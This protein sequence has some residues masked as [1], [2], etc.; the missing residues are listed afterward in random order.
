MKSSGYLGL[1]AIALSLLL[2]AGCSNS[3]SPS[4]TGELKILLTDSPAQY[5]EVN[6][7]VTQ[8]EVHA[9][10]SDSLSGWSVVNNDTATYDLLTLRNGA[11]AILG[12]T[13]LPVGKYTQ[14]R[15]HIGT[16]SNIVVG[17][18]RFPLDVTSDSIVKLNNEFDILSGALYLLTLD[19][20]A[21]KSIVLTGSGHYK[22]NPV[23]RVEANVV[24]GSISGIVNPVSARAMVSTLAG[25]DT[26]ETACDTVS[27][28]FELV[29]LPEGMYDVKISPSDVTYRDTTLTGIQVTAQHNTNVGI[30]VLTH[31]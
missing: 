18:V 5:D 11:N 15:L 3:T 17:G 28:A 23:I 25:T 29:V 10:N 14:I 2:V 12:D 22:L 7:V 27:G 30:V 1:V 6:I 4:G 13:M 8:V 19:F 26:V 31:R 9:V 16:G 21:D 20:D 24:S